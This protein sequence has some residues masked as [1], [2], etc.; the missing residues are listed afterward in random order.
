MKKE[1]WKDPEAHLQSMTFK[2]L[3]GALKFAPQSLHISRRALNFGAM[4]A[5]KYAIRHKWREASWDF[6]DFSTEGLDVSEKKEKW[7]GA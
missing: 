6:E 7:F 4:Q 5:R 1:Q 2:D 3:D